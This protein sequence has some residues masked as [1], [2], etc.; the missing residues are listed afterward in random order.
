MGA[1]ME[2]FDDTALRVL[3]VVRRQAGDGFTLMSKSGL[4]P[5]E[6]ASAV[7]SLQTGQL[8]SVEGVLS[9]DKIGDAYVYVPP[10]AKSRSDFI[11]S[12]QQSR[13]F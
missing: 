10:Q 6:F 4:N 11:I 1:I 5:T 13:V 12:R 9:E 3:G 7:R 2:N 8:V